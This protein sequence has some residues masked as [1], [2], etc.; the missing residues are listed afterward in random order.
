MTCDE[1]HTLLHGYVDE[2]LEL[3]RHLEVERHLAECPDCALDCKRL[4]VLRAALRGRSFRF[5][6]P[7]TRTEGQTG[8]PVAMAISSW[9]R[10]STA[11]SSRLR[12]AL[13]SR[14]GRDSR[15]R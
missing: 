14:P 11:S 15:G 3:S 4:G 9:L 8:S 1:L 5:A 6:A 10:V 7:P 12:K 2:E 13:R